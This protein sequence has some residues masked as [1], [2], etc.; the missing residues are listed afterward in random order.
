M[1]ADPTLPKTSVP[2][3]RS[4]ESST[5]VNPLRVVGVVDNNLASEGPVILVSPRSG[6][7]NWLTG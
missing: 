2:F 6:A 5:C 7:G 3:L 4:A 1:I